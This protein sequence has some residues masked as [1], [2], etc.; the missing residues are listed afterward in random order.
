M[1]RLAPDAVLFFARYGFVGLESEVNI[2]NHRSAGWLTWI[3]VYTVFVVA[4]RDSFAQE[5]WPRFRGAAATG[6][7]ADD[8]RLPVARWDE[9]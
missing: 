8:P 1:K 9:A 7:A 3:V 5:N 4:I 2:M 6:V